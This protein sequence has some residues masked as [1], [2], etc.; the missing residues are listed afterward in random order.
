M[1]VKVN[2][3]ASRK[4]GNRSQLGFTLVELTIALAVGALVLV[5][6]MQILHHMVVTSAT[7]RAQATALL[8]VQYVGFWISEDVI[9]ASPENV[10]IGDGQGFPLKIEWTTWGGDVNRVEYRVEPGG[11]WTLT[12]TREHSLRKNGESVFKSYGN[13]TVGEFLDPAGTRCE[14][15][16]LGNETVVKL[17]VA[18]DVDGQV[19]SRTYEVYPRG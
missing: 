16:M 7:D 17:D 8:Q 6:S 1:T 15:V 5:G 13:A 14:T 4:K 10:T 9:Q 12:L 18:A 3:L 19:A 11:I 2:P